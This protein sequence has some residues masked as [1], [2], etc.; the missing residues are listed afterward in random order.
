MLGQEEEVENFINQ[1]SFITNILSQLSINETV[2]LDGKAL[3]G[4]ISLIDQGAKLVGINT[5]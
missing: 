4:L 1:A 2:T 3:A 5:D